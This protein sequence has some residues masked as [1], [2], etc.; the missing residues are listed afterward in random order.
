MWIT[1]ILLF[2]TSFSIVT[3]RL[4][5]QWTLFLFSPG[6]QQNLRF[7]AN[8]LSAFEACFESAITMARI[9][10]ILDTYGGEEDCR[11]NMPAKKMGLSYRIVQVV[12]FPLNI[13]CFDWTV[14]CCLHP[15]SVSL[16]RDQI[17]FATSGSLGPLFMTPSVLTSQQHQ[18]SWRSLQGRWNPF[19]VRIF[20]KYDEYLQI[21]NNEIVQT[22]WLPKRKNL[23]ALPW[24]WFKATK[25]WQK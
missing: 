1:L 14:I 15:A 23:E 17:S 13:L 11:L 2:K 21:S 9:V 3:T 20:M 7:L 19:P 16:W 18:I 10:P 12:K 8:F 5:A 24:E 22:E 4:L 25:S 6:R